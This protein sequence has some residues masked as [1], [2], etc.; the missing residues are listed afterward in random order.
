MQNNEKFFILG[1]V[2]GLVIPFFENLVRYQNPNI[3]SLLGQMLIVSVNIWEY[4]FLYLI[5]IMTA[6]LFFKKT[7]E[8]LNQESR[9]FFFI[10]GVALGF[11]TLSIITATINAIT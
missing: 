7:R 1:S 3:T 6:F 9:F 4:V 8:K 2:L 5:V 11:A 10:S